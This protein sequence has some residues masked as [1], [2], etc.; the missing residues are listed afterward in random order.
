MPSFKPVWRIRFLKIDAVGAPQISKCIIREVVA[1]CCLLSSCR[2]E[3]FGTS[4]SNLH[5]KG[6]L[7][8]LNKKK[9]VF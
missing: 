4:S 2:I 5:W 7:A 6:S 9:S 8:H 1:V 3:H